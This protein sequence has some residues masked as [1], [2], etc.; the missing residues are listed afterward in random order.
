[1]WEER[2]NLRT[3][4]VE[5]RER[6]N[7][8]ERNWVIGR[9]VAQKGISGALWRPEQ[10][11]RLTVDYDADVVK[12]AELLDVLRVYGLHARPARIET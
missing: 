7:G 3:A 9:L 4:N 8:P 6:L 12:G 10:P 2:Q 1:M 5:V 11:S